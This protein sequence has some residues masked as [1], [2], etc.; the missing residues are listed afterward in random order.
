MGCAC[1]RTGLPGGRVAKPAGAC[2]AQAVPVR[3]RPS[4]PH[5]RLVLIDGSSYLYRAFHALP[6]LTNSAGEPTGALF[7]V[8]NMLRA[9]LNSKPDYAAFVQDAPGPTFRDALYAE[10]KANREAMP[11]PLAA[12]IEPMLAIVAALGFP[13]LRV[14]GV[15]ADDVIGTLAV[16]ARQGRHRCHGLHRRQGFRA[17]RRA[18]HRAGQHHEQHDARRCR[19]RREV[20]RAAGAHRRSARADGRQ[21]RQHSGRR[22]MRAEDRGEMARRIRHARRRDRKRRQGR[23]QDRREPAQGAA[24]TAAVAP[25]GDDQDRCRARCRSGGSETARTRR[26]LRCARCT[27]ATNSMPR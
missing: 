26:R 5:P 13:I 25:A 9:T 21:R 24:A 14:E 16:E 8:V 12:Q 17:A 18:G 23:R 4:M 22:E 7:G 11:D 3:V 15:E 10:Y 2:Q 20:R 6:P 27:S 19:R 1:H